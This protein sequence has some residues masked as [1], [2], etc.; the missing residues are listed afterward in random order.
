MHNGL[1]NFL[2]PIA[3]A[4]AVPS[5]SFESNQ[6]SKRKK[7]PSRPVKPRKKLKNIKVS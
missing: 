1:V 7:A 3:K 6:G 4:W 2:D 5:V